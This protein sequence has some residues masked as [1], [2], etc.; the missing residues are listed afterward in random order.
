VAVTQTLVIND[1]HGPWHDQKA[2]SLILHSIEHEKIDRLVINGDL[3]DF[4]NIS[5]HGPKHPDIQ[6][7]L[8]DEIS[9]GFN[10]FKDLRARFPKLH[11]VY[12]F[13]NHEN[14]LDRFILNNCPA[15][16]NIVR[17][18]KM[19][20]LEKFDIEFYEYNHLYQL[21]SSNLYVQHSP[22]SY[23]V[24]AAMT[25]LKKKLDIS[26]IYGC[27]HRA[28]HASMTGA[29]GK[30]HHAWLNGNLMDNGST[31]EHRRVFS[32]TKGHENWQKCFMHV[33][34]EDGVE[35]HC[36]QIPIVNNTFYLNGHRYG[37]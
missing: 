27:T 7:V 4:I 11:I 3:L 33:L 17:L 29:S 18:E 35:F 14:R 20:N 1:I 15:F 32:Y 19:L 6:A 37:F 2:M 34:I 30:V 24:N 26:V 36:N 9:W 28:Q 25:S 16:W 5:S 12:L 13:G 22:P 31:A 10:F 21:E 23:A 8:D